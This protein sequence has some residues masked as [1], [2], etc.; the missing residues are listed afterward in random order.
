MPL[1]LIRQSDGTFQLKKLDGLTREFVDW[2]DKVR[3]GESETNAITGVDNE[4]AAVG[5]FIDSGQMTTDATHTG[6]TGTKATGSIEVDSVPTNDD[7]LTITDY[8]GYAYEFK[9]HSSTTG[10]YL[11]GRY[12]ST[13]SGTVNGVAAAL[14][15]AIVEANLQFTSRR[16]I[17]SMYE[18]EEEGIGI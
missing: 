3:A 9:F 18:V 2:K 6:G 7:T 1:V 12:V 11:N 14:R 4:N 8:E 10:T 13:S 17:Q 5:N 16:I 15:Q